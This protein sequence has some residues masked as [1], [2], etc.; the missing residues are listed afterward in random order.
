M[1]DTYSE[2][3]EIRSALQDMRD[4]YVLS[5]MAQCGEIEYVIEHLREY[6]Y[7]SSPPSPPER[8]E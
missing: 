3:F 7:T 2:L 6:K 4:L 5:I 1:N 8:D